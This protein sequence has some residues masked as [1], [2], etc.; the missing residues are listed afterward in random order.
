LVE[1]SDTLQSGKRCT[2]PILPRAATEQCPDRS[3]FGWD[4]FFLK[5]DL[6]DEIDLSNLCFAE[7]STKNANHSFQVSVNRNK[8]A[9]QWRRLWVVYGL[10]GRFVFVNSTSKYKISY[11]LLQ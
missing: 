3:N 8:F 1:L 2:S 7:C 6:F 11:N 10:T 9:L 4:S 5:C